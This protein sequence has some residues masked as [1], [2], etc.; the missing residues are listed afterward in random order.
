MS[1]RFLKEEDDEEELA[2]SGVAP[3]PSAVKS[4]AAYQALLRE[5]LLQQ[6]NDYESGL[7]SDAVNS[8]KE[9]M[10]QNS[11][12]QSA[13]MNQALQKMA[14]QAG[15]LNGKM[16][17]TS[18]TDTATKGMLEGIDQNQAMGLKDKESKAKLQQYLM[19][20]MLDQEGSLSKNA[21]ERDKLAQQQRNFDKS[22]NAKTEAADAK[23]A[24]EDKATITGLAQKNA[25]KISIANQMQGYLDQYRNAKS[26]DQ[27]V[28]IGRQMIKVLNSPEGADAVGS[29]ESKRLGS[30]IEY[31]MFNMR[32]PGPMFGRDLQGFDTQVVDTINS[33]KSGVKK[34]NEMIS[35]I[36]EGRPMDLAPTAPIERG[37]DKKPGV[38]NAA[39]MPSNKVRVSN[40]KET[41]LIDRADLG[42]AVND[43]YSEVK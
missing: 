28:T 6:M 20:K 26:D 12:R 10:A 14:S 11:M 22:L 23:M 40:G 34:N 38:A 19:G 15:S 29:E 42:D 17:D 3:N 36:K 1:N 37:G 2:S 31:Q 21:L 4:D 13:L 9:R 18:L 27:K 16:S 32:N 41:L 35:S 30:L 24:P 7:K 5:K 33:V 25:A 39:P 43:G 8:G